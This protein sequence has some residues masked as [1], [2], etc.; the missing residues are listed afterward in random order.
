MATMEDLAARVFVTRDLAHRAH[1]AT[2]SLSRHMALG[3]LYGSLPEKIDAIVETY[4]G[5]AELIKPFEVKASAKDGDPTTFEDYL[6]SEAEWIEE[7]REEIADGNTAI[8]NL[9]DDLL[10][11]YYRTIYKLTQLA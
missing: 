6:F 1:W 3:D 5:A 9:I 2:K 11:S 10:Q 4:Q 7:C 8:E